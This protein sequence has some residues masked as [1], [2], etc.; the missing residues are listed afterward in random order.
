M[1]IAVLV[2][3][4]PAPAQLRMADGRIVRHGVDLEVNAY[5][6]RANAKAVEL[7]GRDG[8]VVVFTMGPRSADD[9]L[10]EMI[11]AGATRGVHLC[12]S[13]FAGS[14]TL[15]TAVAL[16]AALRLV[17]PFDLVL[18]GLNSLDSD[19]GQVPAETAELLGLPFAPGVRD[20]QISAPAPAAPAGAPSAAP[21]GSASSAPRRSFTARLETDDGFRTVTG[22]LPVMLSTAE[23]LTYPSKAP[24][25]QR[26]AVAADRIT[27]LTAAD[28]DVPE[29]RLGAVGSPTSVGPVRVFE[30]RRRPVRAATAAE[31]VDL[32]EA[33]GAFADGA[34]HADQT[35]QPGRPVVPAPVVPAPVA[36]APVAPAPVSPSGVD[37]GPDLWCFFTEADIGAELLGEAAELAR[38]VSGRVT[39]V[40]TEARLAA[41]G[42]SR[43]SAAG[44][45]RVLVIPAAP[46]QPG[47]PSQPDAPSDAPE[48]SEQADALSAAAAAE[49]PWALLIEG[50]RTGRVVA[51][52][53][54]ARN[55][56][57]LTG[58]ATALEVGA[59]RR[60]VAWKPAFGGR[61]EAP[62]RSRSPVQM[63]TI[64]PGVLA[65]RPPRRPPAAPADA[66]VATL[67]PPPPSR[68]RTLSAERDDVDV[69]G[70]RRASA[71]VALGQGVE[72][73]G[74]PVIDELR[75]ALGGAAVG[76]TRK[77][78]DK[79][80]I[81]RNRQIGV[82]GHS[83]APR[84]LVAVGSSG[85]F[86]HTVGIR[87]AGV[88]LAVNSNPEAEIFDQVDVGLVG[89][90]QQAVPDL[91]AELKSRGLTV[92]P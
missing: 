13:A 54:A 22:E 53:V 70:L 75:S 5:C 87:N 91:T 43:L 25:E 35:G 3:Q 67:A 2:K 40:T 50:T 24:P 52:A 15:A 19:T 45:D 68:L 82:T 55:G 62:I 89:A 4:I 88:I 39:A 42:I 51:S 41:D 79:A 83:V 31:A 6:R 1:R 8:E 84:L 37:G 66:E 11:A 46:S 38:Q 10:R 17:G 56:W 64:R 86:N 33:L 36:P 9:A 16:A 48:P 34:G 29:R 61:V 59:D 7:A 44:A 21:A 81:P 49:L 80:W 90:W 69:G 32:L 85:R 60:L 74:Y 77:V 72:P 28:L 76:G 63:A 57:G 18:A 58:D 20:L 47:D 71:I 92:T 78:T 65:L 73:S 27:R 30:T 14:D 23:R 26:R 12:D